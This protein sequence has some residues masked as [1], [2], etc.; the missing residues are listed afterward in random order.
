MLNF[1]SLCVDNTSKYN[2]KRAKGKPLCVVAQQFPFEE[3]AGRRAPADRV[4][5]RDWPAH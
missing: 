3:L 2:K 1:L 4:L 5:E